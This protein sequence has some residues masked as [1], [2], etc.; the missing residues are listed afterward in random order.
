MKNFTYQNPTK[1]IFGENTIPQIGGEL[2]ANGVKKVLLTYGKKSIKENGVYNQVIKSLQDKKIEWVEYSGIQSNPL[3]SHANEGAKYAVA[4]EVDAILA[5]GGGSVIDE[6]KGIAAGAKY[7]G[8]IWDLILGKAQV[9]DALPV[10]TIL[11]IP[12]TG[13]EMNMGLVLTNDETLD[14]FGWGNPKLY[15]KVSILDPSVTLT[16][17][18]NQTAFTSID[19]I[20]HSIEAYFT[21]EDNDTPYLDGYVENLV[22]SVIISVDR[23]LENPKDLNA[24]AN[25]MWT[26]TNAWNGTNHCGVGSFFL[27]NH[28]MEHPISAVYNLAHG[29]GLSILIPAWMKHFKEQ[30]R[31]KL[32]QFFKAIFGNANVEEGINKFQ[33]WFQKIGA[34]TTFTQAGIENVDIK[35]LTSLAKRCGDHRGTNLTED[36]LKSIYT[37]VK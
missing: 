32:S 10:Y 8:C 2:E 30:K 20:A 24:R 34:P 27:N 25:L 14:K 26:A 37:L 13:S 15:P 11:T 19:I 28:Q 23:I 9:K 4:N 35:K 5:V 3:L 21:K 1:I 33:L 18:K 7:A 16:V 6:S 29:E 36:D 17:P 31:E 22:K 12:A